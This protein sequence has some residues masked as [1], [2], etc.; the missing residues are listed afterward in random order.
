MKAPCFKATLKVQ[1]HQKRRKQE[2][3]IEAERLSCW[4]AGV[5]PDCAREGDKVLFTEAGYQVEYKC[6]ACR[7]HDVFGGKEDE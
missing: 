3:A 1:Q 6:L 7:A 2:A 4:Q 5:C